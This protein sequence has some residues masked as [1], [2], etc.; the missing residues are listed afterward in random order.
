VIEKLEKIS[1]LAIFITRSPLD[2]KNIFLYG[3]YVFSWRL[4]SSI[5]KGLKAREPEERI[6]EG[7]SANS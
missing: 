5:S 7:E 2:G 3:Q 1:R 6:V 4:S